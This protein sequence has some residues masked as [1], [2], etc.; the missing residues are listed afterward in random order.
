MARVTCREALKLLGV[1][2]A[3]FGLAGRAAGGPASDPAGR[4]PNIVVFMTDDQRWDALS[5]AGNAILKTPNMDRIAAAGAR[6]AKAFVTNSLCGP[7]RASFLTGLYSHAHS[8]ISNADP[9]AFGDQKGIEPRTTYVEL[10]RDTGYRTVLVGKWHLR[11]SPAESG[12]KHWVI[13]P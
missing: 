4:P 13:F 3:G 12:F 1:S 2:A 7:S 6:F 8:Y 11:N 9:P 5:A 10:L